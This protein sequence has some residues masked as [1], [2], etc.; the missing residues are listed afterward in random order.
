M[1]F[2]GNSDDGK[3]GS[4]TEP[5]ARPKHGRLMGGQVEFWRK[6]CLSRKTV[7]RYVELSGFSKFFGE[8]M[9]KTLIMQCR[10][11]KMGCSGWLKVAY[12]AQVA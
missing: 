2:C 6:T 9:Q 7:Q 1:E 8:K 5:V 3:S 11:D 12:V 10:D 4:F